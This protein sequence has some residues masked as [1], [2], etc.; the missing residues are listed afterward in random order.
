MS[1]T[2]LLLALS[3][4]FPRPGMKLP[5][6]DA[7]YVIGAVEP[8][9]TN[10]VV[11]GRE[12]PVHPSGAW[13]A[14]V[15]VHSGTNTLTLSAVEG[16]VRRTWRRTF[17][18]AAK[19][20]PEPAVPAA[21]R[22]YG[23]LPYAADAAQ[24]HPAGVA[25]ARTTIVLDPGHGG[26]SDLGA[27]SPHGRSEKEANLL[28]AGDV[29]AALEKRGYRVV[30]TRGDDRPIGLYDRPKT[31]HAEKAAAFVSLH[32][33]APP[34][35]RDAGKIRYA[36]VYAWNPLGS[37]LAAAVAKR[38]AATDAAP[39]NKGALLA[40]YAVTRNPQIPS[41]L[42]EADFITHPEGEAAVWDPVR[43]A[44]VGEAIAAGI[45]DWHAAP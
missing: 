13:T 12:T 31:A 23:K 45:A 11:A 42:V 9:V 37:A 24:P 6:I 15:P 27:L 5:A 30:L 20:G 14:F 2:A 34:A 38:L 10:I 1:A 36:C 26:P 8:G 3:V 4:A 16:G 17:T 28:L 7:C 35:D 40:N 43:R 41:C 25:P 32:H 44:A 29:R 33:N 18:V 21:P 22:V 19:A 39:P